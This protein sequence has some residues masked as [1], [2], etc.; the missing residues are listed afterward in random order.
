MEHHLLSHGPAIL[1]AS[2]QSHEQP[3][4]SQLLVPDLGGTYTHWHVISQVSAHQ[5]VH[6][7]MSPVNWGWCGEPTQDF[8][9]PSMHEK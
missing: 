2:R 4:F 9:P 5:C 8:T 1:A 3:R 7:Q 6:H